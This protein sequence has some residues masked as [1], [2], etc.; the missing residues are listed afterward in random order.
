MKPSYEEIIE[1]NPRLKNRPKEEVEKLLDTIVGK[2]YSWDNKKNYFYHEG[3][4]M[5]IRTQGLD[6]FD[7][8]RFEK[9]FQTWSNPEHAEA[10]RTAHKWIPILLIIFIID[11]ILGWFFI[12]VK[13]WIISLIFIGLLISFKK[14]V[15]KMIREKINL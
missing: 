8:E 3:L 7:P 12:P 5:Y 11:L 14:D 6:L 9:A 4:G 10:A 2:G 15:F 13:I 1:A